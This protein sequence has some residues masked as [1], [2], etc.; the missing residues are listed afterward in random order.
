MIS[1]DGGK[2]YSSFLNIMGGFCTGSEFWMV[3]WPYQ[4]F[5]QQSP[6]LS[7]RA[8]AA[9]KLALFVLHQ[10]Y[11]CIHLLLLLIYIYVY[12]AFVPNLSASSFSFTQRG[13]GKR[14]I[15]FE[16]PDAFMLKILLSLSLNYDGKASYQSELR[17]S[18]NIEERW[19]ERKRTFD[20]FFY[21]GGKPVKEDWNPADLPIM[22]SREERGGFVLYSTT[23]RKRKKSCLPDAIKSTATDCIT[24]ERRGERW[25]EEENCPADE[26]HHSRCFFTRPSTRFFVTQLLFKSGKDAYLES[27]KAAR[28]LER[29]VS[30]MLCSWNVIHVERERPAT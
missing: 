16:S 26:L 2:I 15:F 17:D 23:T 9:L 14:A 25:R 8:F 6:F 21:F 22:R 5:W 4:Q 27:L 20:S 29:L 3:T 18:L 30:L 7:W 12:I 28:M 1:F 11:L 10:S 13:W 19:R 24:W